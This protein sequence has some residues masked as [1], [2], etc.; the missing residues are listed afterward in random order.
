MLLGHLNRHF[1][2][3]AGKQN[4]LKIG[5]SFLYWLIFLKELIF[6]DLTEKIDQPFQNRTFARPKLNFCK[7]DRKCNSKTFSSY[8]RHHLSPGSEQLWVSVVQK[9][10]NS[11]SFRKLEVKCGILSVKHLFLDIKN[12]T[13]YTVFLCVVLNLAK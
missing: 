9:S 1:L 12:C 11:N 7:C 8:L 4:C 2:P 6:A 5:H 13:K 3:K 10:K